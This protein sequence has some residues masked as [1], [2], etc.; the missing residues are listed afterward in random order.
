MSLP[1]FLIIMI[2]GVIIIACVALLI[3]P[4]PPITIEP[5]VDVDVPEKTEHTITI[6]IKGANYTELK[7]FI[8][9]L[10]EEYRNEN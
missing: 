10:V 9:E 2:T 6:D 3:S 7:T 4:K 8:K 5:K 1:F